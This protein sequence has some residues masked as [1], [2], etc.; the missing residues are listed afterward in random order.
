MT[1]LIN[2]F[3][4]FTKH[5]WWSNYVRWRLP[6]IE[7]INEAKKQLTDFVSLKPK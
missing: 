2:R 3:C 1:I 4:Q 7:F 6:P 5:K